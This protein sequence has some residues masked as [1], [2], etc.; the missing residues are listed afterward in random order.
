M[1]FGCER[2]GARV[3]FISSEI[4][5]SSEELGADEEKL[6]LNLKTDCLLWLLETYD[7]FFFFCEKKIKL[8]EMPRAKWLTTKRATVSRTRLIEKQRLRGNHHADPS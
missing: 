7:M 1:S 5:S 6:L 3:G 4:G 8:C 2:S